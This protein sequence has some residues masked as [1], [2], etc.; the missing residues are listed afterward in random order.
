V[1]TQLLSLVS[2]GAADAYFQAYAQNALR[3]RRRADAIDVVLHFSNGR[4]SYKDSYAQA[5]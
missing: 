1:P 2:Q 4:L 5:A 3:L